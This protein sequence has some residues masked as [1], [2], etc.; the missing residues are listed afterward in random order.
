MFE[1]E[2][3]ESEDK[4]FA[5]SDISSL[6]TALF[7]VNLYILGI[8]FEKKNH[9]FYLWHLDQIDDPIFCILG[10]SSNQVFGDFFNQNQVSEN[11]TNPKPRQGS[12]IEM[13]GYP[14]VPRKPEKLKKNS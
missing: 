10:G 11:P 2:I 8:I 13:N 5:D 1:I 7:S 14:L 6:L 12:K 4:I 3:L 9:E